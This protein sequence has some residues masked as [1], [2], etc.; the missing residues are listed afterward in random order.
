FSDAIRDGSGQRADARADPR[1]DWWRDAKFGVFIHWGLYAIPAGIWHDQPIDGI[2]EWLMLRARVP[3]REY[4]QLA[5]QFNPVPSDA[6]FDGYVEKYV[7]PQVREL[8]SNY[9]PIGLIWFDTPKRMTEAQSRS[10]VDFVH[11]LQPE[12]LVN[13]RV[14]NHLGDYASTRDNLIPLE[15]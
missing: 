8:L 6:E 1:L 15:Q 4:E 7:K 14:G 3:V 10:L 12:C 2:G 13:G 11:E 9:G 5:S